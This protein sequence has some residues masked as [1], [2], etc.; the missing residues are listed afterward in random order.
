MITRIH[1]LLLLITLSITGC[2][3]TMSTYQNETPRFVPEQWFVG[4][5]QASGGFFDRFGTLRRRFVMDLTGRK[6]GETIRLDEEL[7][8]TDGEIAKRSYLIRKTDGNR[9]EATAD[10]VVGKATIDASGNALRW[11]YKLKQKIGES[12]WTLSFDDWM[13]LIDERTMLDRAEVS[14]WGIKI[15]E[16]ILV[17]HKLEVSSEAKQ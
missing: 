10:G 17:A 1:I 7:R 9:Y 12:D 3:A 14:K 6:E 8:Y 2:G 16:V 4:R 11:V 13:Y 5:F 15:G